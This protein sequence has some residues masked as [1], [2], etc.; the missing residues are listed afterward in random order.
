MVGKTRMGLAQCKYI[1][2]EH[3][4]IEGAHFVVITTGLVSCSVSALFVLCYTPY[5]Q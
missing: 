2:T 3:R 4:H 1:Q 5:A